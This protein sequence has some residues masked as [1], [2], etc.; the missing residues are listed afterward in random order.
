MFAF[1]SISCGLIKM[2]FEEL[3]MMIERNSAAMED[4]AGQLG[5]LAG[6]LEELKEIIKDLPS[7]F[8]SQLEAYN[9]HSKKSGIA[10][11]RDK[12]IPV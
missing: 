8:F 2:I 6:E 7:E 10:V 11:S 12:N 3:K 1:G 5:D 4:I 9:Q